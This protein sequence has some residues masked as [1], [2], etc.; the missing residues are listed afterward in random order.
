LRID[1]H[2][3]SRVSDGTDAPADLVREAL[4][5]RL[6]VLALTDHDTYAGWD[7]AGEAA[8]GSGL[9]FVPG[10]EISTELGGVG[11]HLL[12]YLV[13]PTYEPLS[14][15]LDLVRRDRRTRLTAVTNRLTAAGLELTVDD[16]LAQ[17]D[18]AAT[19]GRPHV[20]DAMIARGYVADREE[21]F[22]HWLA[23][24]RPGFVRKYAPAT[25]DA[26]GLVRAAG[27]AVVLAHPWG[28]ASRRVLD[29]RAVSALAAAGLD[30]LEVDHEDHSPADRV[31]LRRLARELGLVVTGSSDHHGEGK[32]DHP[33][34]INTTDPAEY[35][36]LLRRAAASARAAGRRTV[37][38][39][40]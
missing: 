9:I 26:I 6:D 3:H 20:A 33:L 12:G 22:T 1:L 11:V 35:E 4:R 21:A 37:G 17:A 15:E 14:A 40:A 38:P 18:P 27:G 31:A 10:V 13:D 16:V 7:E 5:A 24:G 36:E 28:R 30:G 19:V 39:V 2:S 25:V 32:V 34:G 29:E 23:E 8:A